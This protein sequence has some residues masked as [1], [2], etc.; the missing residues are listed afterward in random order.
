MLLLMRSLGAAATHYIAFRA[1]L[2]LVRAHL[3]RY[4][5]SQQRHDL[6]AAKGHHA[7]S[8]ALLGDVR[9]LEP[10]M[11]RLEDLFESE[12]ELKN[13][14]EL[15]SAMARELLVMRSLVKNLQIEM[16]ALSASEQQAD[17]PDLYAALGVEKQATQ[18]PLTRYCYSKRPTQI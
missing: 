4:S 15:H 9:L 11:D 10:A 7:N 14:L 8:R 6:N 5:I 12:M 16:E 18:I 3:Q 2:F 17:S 1:V 13:A